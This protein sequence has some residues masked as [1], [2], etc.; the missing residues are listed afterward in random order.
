M[1]LPTESFRGAEKLMK[2]RVSDDA[3]RIVSRIFEAWI[4]I[5]VAAFRP[6]RNQG[7]AATL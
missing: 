4:S 2:R 6:R 5:A 3:G 1:L 7:R